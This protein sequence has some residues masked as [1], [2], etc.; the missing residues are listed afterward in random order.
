VKNDSELLQLM[1]SFYDEKGGFFSDNIDQSLNLFS[2]EIM[3]NSLILNGIDVV[4]Q[5]QPINPLAIGNAPENF[6]DNYNFSVNK[7]EKTYNLTHYNH[8]Y[9]ENYNFADLTHLDYE[10]RQNYSSNFA[11]FLNETGHL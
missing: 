9:S 4:F 2:M 3:V 6:W 1:D 7:L 8:F 10:G 11:K 5:S